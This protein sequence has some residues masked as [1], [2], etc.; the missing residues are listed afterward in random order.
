[1]KE[2]KEPVMEIVAIT[3]DVITASCGCVDGGAYETE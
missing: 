2:Y 3:A 1:M